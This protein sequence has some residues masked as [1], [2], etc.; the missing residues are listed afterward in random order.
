[1]KMLG[2]WMLFL[3]A[4][5]AIGADSV[6]AAIAAHKHLGVASC[7]S[8]VCHGSTQ[9]FKE[10]SVMQN[11]FAYWQEFDP[12]ANKAFQALTGEA[13]QA[14][15][16]KLG[17][18]DATQAAVCLDCHADNVPGSARGDRFQLSD[19][20]GCEACHGGSELWISSHTERGAA[21]ADN[22]G[23]GMYPTD[24]AVQRAQLCLSC[25][26]GTPDRMITHRIMG[27]GH[28]RLSFELDTFT[29]LNPHYTI[30]ADYI[31][32]KGDFNGLRDW[33]VGQGVA[34]TNL[35]DLLLDDKMG[36]NGIFPELVLFD[37]YSCHKVMDSKSWGPRQGTGLG[38][39]AVRLN[40]SNLVMFRHVLAGIDAGASK[41]L[42][43]QTRALHQATQQGR[44]ATRAPPSRR[45][46]PR[47]RPRRSTPTCSRASWPASPA[48]AS[49]A[50]TATMPRPSRRRWRC[51]RSWSPGRTSADST[52]SGPSCCKARSTSSPMRSTTAT[53][54]R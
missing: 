44:D 8:G 40:D 24:N 32:R 39:G 14:I 41:R 43:D 16:R 17:L 12:H 48:T 15:A 45:N 19:G 29:W 9:V 22:L 4:P 3:W 52:R 54:T 23:K 21:H 47:S 46:C 31:E 1:M 36:W 25:H 50:S 7:A 18:G 11:E 6:V 2:W 28:P 26:M 35:L 38:P 42:R 49:A 30:D 13:G 27:A 37:C 53:S 51:N 10:S 33:G 34:A 20:V 5:A